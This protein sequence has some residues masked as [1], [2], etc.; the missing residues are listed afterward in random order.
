VLAA[1]KYLNIGCGEDYKHTSKDQQGSYNM[2]NEQIG[3]HCNI[4]KL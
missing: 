2:L 3:E 1:L 4:M